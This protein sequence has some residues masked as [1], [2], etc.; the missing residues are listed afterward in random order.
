MRHAHPPLIALLLLVAA[1]QAPADPPPSSATTVPAPGQPA[2]AGTEVLPTPAGSHN[3]NW[4]GIVADVSEFRRRGQ[5]LTAVVRLRNQS[6]AVAVMELS[7]DQVYVID[8]ATGK[9][10][11]VLKDEK[12]AYIASAPRFITQGLLRNQEMLVWMKFPALPPETH[13][14]TLVVPQ[15]APFEDLPI[16]S[17]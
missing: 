1:C 13:T 10:Y 7:F 2:S 11:E 6:T 17:Q 14:A 4:P 5:V 3:T 9:K 8:E 15:M 16:Q 12:D